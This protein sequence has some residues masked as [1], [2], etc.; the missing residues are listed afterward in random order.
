MLMEFLRGYSLLLAASFLLYGV[1]PKRYAYLRRN[2][3]GAG[4]YEKM[5]VRIA[6]G[7]ATYTA[8]L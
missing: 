5:A 3:R 2:I 1:G 7:E 4:D 6:R 8:P